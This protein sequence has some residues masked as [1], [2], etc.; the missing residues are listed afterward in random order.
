MLFKN[1]YIYEGRVLRIGNS[2]FVLIESV[3]IGINTACKFHISSN[4][5]H[6]DAV[7]KCTKIT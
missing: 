4:P 3:D 7:T 5:M 1:C 6:I 2:E